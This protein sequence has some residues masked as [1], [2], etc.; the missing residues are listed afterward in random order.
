[1]AN[2]L[3]LLWISLV[4][5]LK[6]LHFSF[7]QEGIELFCPKL[8]VHYDQM[9]NFAWISW[10]FCPHFH[11]LGNPCCSIN[12]QQSR[13]YLSHSTGTEVLYYF[14][15]LFLPKLLCPMSYVKKV[16]NLFWM[17]ISVHSA[18]MSSSVIYT[19]ERL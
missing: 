5:V 13:I 19:K 12:L 10:Y 17:V 11:S 3:D 16:G 9:F 18:V 2:E 6:T 8:I 4:I 14:H 15:R 1:M 7:K